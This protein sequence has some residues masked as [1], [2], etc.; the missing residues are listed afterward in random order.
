MENRPMTQMLVVLDP[1]SSSDARNTLVDEGVR[2]LQSYGKSVAVVEANP[3]QQKRLQEARDVIR[4]AVGEKVTPPENIDSSG[5]MGILAWNLNCSP[6]E[7]PR[8][9][10][11]YSWGYTEA[12]KE[13]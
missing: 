4:A 9:W 3:T 8:K 1:N 6:D 13:G 2:V 10:D 12:E 7:S 11:G 5:R